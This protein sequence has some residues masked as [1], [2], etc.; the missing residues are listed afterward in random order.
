MKRECS[1]YK[2]KFYKK[3]V[4]IISDCFI[5]TRNSA[6][7]MIYNLSRSLMKEGAFVTCIHSGHNPEKN[8]SHFKDYL[9][10]ILSSGLVFINSFK[11]TINS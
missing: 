3:S 1:E 9:A 11:N 7:G 6:S 2:N 5:P 4:C 10:V 8:Q